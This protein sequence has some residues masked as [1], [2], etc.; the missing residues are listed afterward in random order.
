[1]LSA[2]A[3]VADFVTWMADRGVAVIK[4]V[5]DEMIKFGTDLATLVAD[6]IAHPGNGLRDLMQA[7]SDLGHTVKELVQVAIVQPTEDAARKVLQALKDIGTAA[8]DILQASIELPLSGIALVVATILDWF[9]GTYRPMTDAEATEAAGVFGSSIEL[10]K[11]KIAVKSLPVDLIE[12]LNGGRTFTTMYLLN[13]ASWNKVTIDT[14]IHELTHVWQGLQEGPVYMI[15][16][17]EAQLI[18]KGYNYGYDND[19]DGSE[20]GVGAE[21]ALNAAGGVLSSFNEE[22][23]AQI[24]MHYHARKT[25]MPPLD[26]TAWQPYANAVFA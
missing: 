16:A 13:F 18:G 15:E 24:I 2:G 6:M 3:A 10:P 7:L 5:T 21:P 17:L 12:K 19:A 25:A 1:M 20:F 9:P 11:V 8:V 22:Q 14:L 4:G 26:V 23:Q